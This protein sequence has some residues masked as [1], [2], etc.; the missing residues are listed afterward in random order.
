MLLLLTLVYQ[1]ILISLA[2]PDVGASL[3]GYIGL[4]LYGGATLAVGLLFSALTENQIV[5]AFLSLTAL[6]LL[7]LSGQVGTLTSDRNLAVLIRDLSFQGHYLNSF[8][9]GV[10]RLEDVVFFATV[11]L[12]LLFITTRLIESRRWR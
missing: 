9:L 2:P 7:W 11:I 4:W 1:F 3:S 5:A 10:V 6:L 8:P 12:V